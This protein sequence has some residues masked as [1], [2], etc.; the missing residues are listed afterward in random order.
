MEMKN[1]QEK[2]LKEMIQQIEREFVAMEKM[3]LKN[4]P[5]IEIKDL[6]EFLK[7]IKSIG[8]VKKIVS[9]KMMK[10]MKVNGMCY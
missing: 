3:N 6:E 8:D 10:A 9:M 4:Q 2:E 7:K 5:M 1:S